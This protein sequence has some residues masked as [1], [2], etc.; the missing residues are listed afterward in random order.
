MRKEIHIG[1]DF[2]SL[3]KVFD[4]I[5]LNELTEWVSTLKSEVKT[6]G[7]I[8]GETHTWRKEGEP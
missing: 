5:A 7:G 4:G 3:V 6:G 8:P 1:D 2:E